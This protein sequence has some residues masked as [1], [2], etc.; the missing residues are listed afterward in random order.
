MAFIVHYSNITNLES[1][2]VTLLHIDV[3][4]AYSFSFQGNK[5]TPYLEGSGITLYVILTY[6]AGVVLHN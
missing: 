6:L 5:I 1:Q 3:F 2:A 4:I